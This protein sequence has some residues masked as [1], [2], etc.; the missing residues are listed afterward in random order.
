MTKNPI[1]KER[2]I[3]NPQKTNLGHSISSRHTAA[4]KLGI[5][6]DTHGTVPAAVHDALAGVNHIL[7]AGDVGPVDTITE[8]EAIAPVTAVRGNTDFA[9]DLPETRLVEFGGNK[10]LIHHIVDFPVPS[11]TVRAL[12][13]EEQPQIVIFGHTHMPCNERLDGVLYLNPGSPATPRGGAPASVAIVEF[14]N[15]TP[16]ARHIT[17]T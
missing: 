5:I 10:F 1:P 3:L 14:E 13:A 12:L 7:H 4:V 11:Q 15:D 9:I 17:L 16:R 6:S 8:L 2:Q